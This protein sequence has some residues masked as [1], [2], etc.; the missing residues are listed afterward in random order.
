MHEFCLTFSEEG[1]RFPKSLHGS[2]VW[3]GEIS[4][5]DGHALE[6]V[7]HPG[8]TAGSELKRIGYNGTHSCS[9]K[10]SPLAAHFEVH[11]EQGPIL[12][13]HNERVG[14]VQ[15]GQAYKWFKVKI[16]GR[17]SHAGTTPFDY[18]ADPMQAMARFVLLSNEVARKHGGLATHG[19][20]QLQPGSINTIPNNVEI[21]LDI[22]HVKDDTLAAIEAEIKARVDSE[23]VKAAPTARNQ[24]EFTWDVLFDNPATYF[25]PEC[26]AAIKES[27]LASLPAEQ[28]REMVSG[29]GHDSCA[30]SRLVPTGMIFVPCKDGLSHN[31]SEYTTPEDC[32][33]GAQ[34]LLDAAL[35]F[36]SRRKA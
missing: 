26:K 28:V 1:A 2:A 29:A 12:E 35:L 5:A 30:T 10:A 11:I 20:F 13:S 6:D 9:H 25:H 34:V 22:R 7:A 21:T 3:S 15:G 32:A 8:V 23:I 31:P 16:Q 18:R 14:V 27:A 4:L 36:D 19:I 33:L 24:V 17:D